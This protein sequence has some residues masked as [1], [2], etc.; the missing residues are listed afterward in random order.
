MTIKDN[1]M[2]NVVQDDVK[3]LKQQIKVLKR[4]VY[5]LMDEVRGRD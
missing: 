3:V 2:L 5:E 4:L 1:R